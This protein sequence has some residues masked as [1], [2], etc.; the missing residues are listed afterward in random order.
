MYKACLNNSCT[1]IDYLERLLLFYNLLL[2]STISDTG[3]S[4]R[5]TKAIDEALNRFE[6]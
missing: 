6:Q 1:I 3:I 4:L 5:R 2:L